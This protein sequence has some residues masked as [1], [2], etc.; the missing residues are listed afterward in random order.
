MVIRES[1]MEKLT[2]LNRLRRPSLRAV[3]V[4]WHIST[5]IVVGLFFAGS[6]E[7]QGRRARLSSDLSAH[8]SAAGDAPVDVIVTGSQEKVARLAQ[9]H[10]LATKKSLDSGAVFSVTRQQ[11]ALLADDQE[12][13]ALSGNAM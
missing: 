3:R 9:R 6:A 1:Y 13:E 4:I 7:A 10:G 12:V 2:S 11:L 5:V 8:L